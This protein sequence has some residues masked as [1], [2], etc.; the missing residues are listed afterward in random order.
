MGLER[1][2]RSATVDELQD[3][4]LD[5]EIA[6]VVEGVTQGSNGPG[7][8]AHHVASLLAHDEVG[9]A[10][11]DPGLLGQL[12]VQGRQRPQRLGRHLP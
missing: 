10:L 5:L 7:A 6:L 4:G 9:I 8:G 11:A 12:L 2:R 1:A 3:G